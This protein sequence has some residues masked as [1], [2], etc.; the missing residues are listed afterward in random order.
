M[1][2]KPRLNSIPFVLAMLL[3]SV[4]TLAQELETNNENVLLQRVAV[5]PETIFQKFREAGMAPVNYTLTPAENQMVFTA[6][7][8]L[9]PLHQQILMKHLHSISFMEGMPNTALTSP[10]GPPNDRQMFNITFRAGLLHETISE[11]ATAKENS[12]F[13]PGGDANYKVQVEGG[14]M[15]AIIYILLHEAT[16][17]VD[18]VLEL[19]PHPSEQNTTIKATNFTKDIWLETNKPH[20]KYRDPLLDRTFFR[21]RKTIPVSLAPE[22]YQKLAKTPYPSLYAMAAWYEDIAELV[23]IYHLSRKLNQPFYVVVSKDHAKVFR[24]EPM[25]NRLV[26][27][28]L[29]LLTQFYKKEF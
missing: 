1:I 28:R 12:C 3:I 9:T 16:H 2:E 14:Q 4:S 15:N 6:F 26:Q 7:S 8:Y 18:A 19:T 20:P 13:T 29:G 23:T 11:W 21:S 10:V 22:V 5:A 25:N 24:F 27:Q 17:I